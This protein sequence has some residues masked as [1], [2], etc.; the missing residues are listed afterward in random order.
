MIYNEELALRLSF[1]P[2]NHSNASFECT[3][4]VLIG[5]YIGQVICIL[6]IIFGILGNTAL[7]FAISRSSFYRFPYG[8]F[9]L[10]ISIFDIVRLI[11]TAFYFLLQAHLV[12][13][14]VAT[15]TIY[16]VFNR[17]PKNV[18]NWLKVFL[19]IERLITIKYWI[20]NRYNVN[21][22]N[23][24][25]I[26][27]SRQRRILCLI[28]L[29]LI[30]SLISQHPNFIPND[31]I[32]PRIDPARLLISLTPNPNFYYGSTLYNGVLFTIISYII[33]DDLLPITILIIC[34]TVLLYKLR[35]LPLITRKKLVE[36][37]WIL[38]FL[39]IFSI[40]LVPRVFIV[41]VS[42]YVDPKNINDTNISVG[43]YTLQGKISNNFLYFICFFFVRFG[44]GESCDY[45][46]C[47]F[48]E[49]SESTKNCCEICLY[50]T[51]KNT[52][53]AAN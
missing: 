41:F 9:L 1:S 30:C 4:A 24:T 20:R 37:I 8:L 32:L 47:M 33:L 10:F 7:I 43:F 15:V 18:T 48:F 6:C 42:L 49:L 35:H 40:F 12:P 23:T 36:S 52:E 34:N 16:T 31:Y 22:I 19:A 38:F 25:K 51:W 28:F 21:S 50:N 29:L 44:N 27:R 45:W 39:T 11:A 46:L 26:Q 2:N 17:Y 5:F 14:N 13:V 3:Q 53:E